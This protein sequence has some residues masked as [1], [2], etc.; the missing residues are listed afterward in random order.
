MG[1]DLFYG[2]QYFGTV[3]LTDA[4]IIPSLEGAYSNYFLS[5]YLFICFEV[6]GIKS[7]TSTW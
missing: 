4:K 7:E 1:I 3:I 5:V 2:F 6:L